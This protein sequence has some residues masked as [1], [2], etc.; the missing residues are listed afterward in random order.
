MEGVVRDGQGRPVPRALVSLRGVA[1]ARTDS[2]GRYAFI[3]V[4]AGAHQMTIYRPGLQ[5]QSSQVEIVAHRTS[6]SNV[7]LAPHDPSVR[8]QPGPVI[9][10][11]GTGTALQGVVVGKGRQPLAG[12]KV[13]LLRQ[14]AAV[15][16]QTSTTGSY[17]FREIAPGEYRVVVSKF[18]YQ[19]ESDSLE[20][21]AGKTETRRFTLEPVTTATGGLLPT[22]PV[23]P[24]P[25]GSVPQSAAEKP[26]AGVKKPAGPVVVR[27][28]APGSVRGQVLDAKTGRPLAGAAVSIAG[29][30]DL[31]TN[32]SG[33]FVLGNVPPGVYQ[34]VVKRN[35]YA[36][37][38]ASLTVRAGETASVN[39][40]LT[41]RP[42][43]RR[44]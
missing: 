15:S 35:G 3:G 14:L 24:A 17:A 31:L 43:M 4:P 42:A 27:R 36:D 7:K 8:P 6:E 10:S 23:R 16:V 30:R 5:A 20:L 40:R 2:Q 34:V 25:A 13:T 41:P 44:R 1:V 32:Q 11:S 12:A 9:R 21:R 29:A 33:V 18:G 39:V 26:P 28:P 19:T 22:I 38:R 37:G